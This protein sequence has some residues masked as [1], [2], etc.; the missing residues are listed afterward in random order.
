MLLVEAPFVPVETFSRT[1][2]Q[3][4]LGSLIQSPNG[5][6]LVKWV[7][8]GIVGAMAGVVVEHVFGYERYGQEFGL[9]VHPGW[10]GGFTAAA[11]IR[12]F[13]KEVQAR[14]GVEFRPGIMTGYR[15]EET[16]RLY[17]RLGYKLC[18]TQLVKRWA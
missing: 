6:L 12:R 3:R 13:E 16:T 11:L 5:I 4:L 10:R 2:T 7:E 18:G 8:A 1:K 15:V 9:F 17:Q 14:G